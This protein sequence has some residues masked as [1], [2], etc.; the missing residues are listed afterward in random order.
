MAKDAGVEA[1]LDVVPLFETVADLHAAPATLERLFTNPV[2]AGHLEARRRAQTVMIGY[3]DSNK[4]GG[5]LTANW[6]LHLAQR[7]IASVCARHEVTLTLFHGRG[8][9]VG[10]G[11]GP[12][13]RAIL[14][15]PPESVGG[16]LRL[17]E[18]GE[19][20][21]TRYA[22]RHL[23]RRHLEQLV[24]AVLLTS[25]KRPIKSPSRG[26][27]W[28]TALQELS[29]LA[30]K[31]YR[32]LVY[33]TPAL[34]RYLRQATPLDQIERLNIGSRPARRGDSGD[35]TELRAIPWVFAWT[36]SR[37]TL[38]GWFGLGAALTGWASEDS[39]RWDLLGLIY[40]EWPF[41]RTMIDNSQVSMRKADMLIAEVY[42][43]LA[44]AADRD[45]V[46]AAL[47]DEFARTERAICRLS[48]QRDLLDD[49][50]WLQRSIRVR[51]PYID[52]M[53]YI[54]IALL[55]RLR[56]GAEPAEAEALREAVLLSVNGVAAG[57]RNTG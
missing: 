56:S 41:F 11:G 24:H 27:A 35:V 52:P 8:G 30:E 31:A 21:T 48:G 17:T 7:A 29:P 39:D 2:Y 45:T 44:A 20:I 4:D 43:S 16:R 38:P 34:P 50:P 18:Q 6:E 10:R 14:A 53:N 13:N 12:T 42:A 47:R 33:A 55:R 49:A 26:G 3:S 9:S 37:V 36:Q 15:Q 5:Y 28:E 40:R 57:L 23:A 46:F 1:H 19:T 54:Q 22:N 25:G 51:N 32:G